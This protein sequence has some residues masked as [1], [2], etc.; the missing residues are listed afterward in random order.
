IAGTNLI[1]GAF[2]YH[3]DPHRLIQSLVDNLGTERLEIDMLE[4]RGPDFAGV[5][6]RLT[7]LQLVRTGLTNAVMFGPRGSVLHPSE[8][9]HKKPILVERG[10]FRP[11]TLVNVDMLECATR[12]FM[13]EPAV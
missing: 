2:Y 6:N 12:Q 3:S 7:S 13:T 1:Y 11:V 9:L 10:S 5:D 8:V 4:F